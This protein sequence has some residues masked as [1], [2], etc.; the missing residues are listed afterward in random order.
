[1]MFASPLDDGQATCY[2]FATLLHGQVTGPRGPEP[3]AR[4]R[5][6]CRALG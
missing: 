1:M 6:T 3:S 4:S 2:I 5:S